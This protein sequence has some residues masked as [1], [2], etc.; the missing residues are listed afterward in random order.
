ML[1]YAVLP[2]EQITIL[3]QPGEHDEVQ[4]KCVDGLQ[5][6]HSRAWLG[7]SLMPK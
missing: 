6:G 1:D 7:I 3:G 2:N 4:V 5:K